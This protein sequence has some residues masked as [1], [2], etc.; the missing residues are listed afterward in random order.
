MNDLPEGLVSSG[1][2]EIAKKLGTISGGKI[3]DVA[4]QSGGFINTLKKALKDYDSFIG[5]D[6]SYDN[7]ES[8][9]KD[10][11]GEPVEF[12]EMNAERLEFESNSFDTVSLS[13]SLH[14]LE[15]IDSVLN[16][17]KRV[18][19]PNGH[20]IIQEPYC[21]GEQTEA[22]KAD[23]R[24]HHWGSEIDNLLDIPHRYTFI[25]REIVQIFNNL[26]LKT[27]KTFETTHYVKCL[28]CE[29]KFE[30]D[31]PKND[32]IIN[33]TFKEIERDLNRLKTVKNHP[34]GKKLKKE[35]EEIKNLIKEVG[36]SPAS[37]LFFIGVK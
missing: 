36:V 7:L 27:E 4:T 22:Q 6:I 1:A 2:L 33:F 12:I 17:M 10:F 29:D 3:L 14:H 34:D 8:V 19:K 20:F 28:F 21:D 37:H 11:K 9:K 30:C 25:K 31:D 23:I 5:I 18:L 13:H 35:G 24:Q 32:S 15:N 16:E 26:S